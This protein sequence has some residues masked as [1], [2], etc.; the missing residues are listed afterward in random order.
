MEFKS[1]NPTTTEAWKK[2][3]VHFSEIEDIHMMDFFHQE[4]DRN[5]QYK[6]NWNEFQFDFSKNKI[7]R[8]TL[9]LL[10]QLAD[11][12]ELKEAIQLQFEGFKINEAGT[13]SITLLI[14]H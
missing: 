4:P 7:N 14:L 1:V 11:E 3:A 10:N 6:I 9:V 12:V 13:A 2:L 5:Q 8:K